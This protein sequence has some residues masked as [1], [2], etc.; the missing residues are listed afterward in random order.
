MIGTAS[1]SCGPQFGNTYGTGLGYNETGNTSL[2]VILSGAG[3]ITS[4]SVEIDGNGTAQNLSL[5]VDTTI[6]AGPTI[7]ATALNSSGI[8]I[9]SDGGNIV[10]STG[11]TTTGG[12]TGGPFPSANPQPGSQ[13]F[14]NIAG[15]AAETF[16]A[17]TVTINA[18]GNVTGGSGDGIQV[19]TI[20]GDVNIT[21]SGNGTS[22]IQ[23]TSPFTASAGIAVQTVGGNVTIIT[24]QG[25]SVDSVNGDGI[26]VASTSGNI[27][28][29]LLDGAINANT[30]GVG[31]AS[32]VS[33]PFTPL[34]SQPIILSPG[35]NLSTGGTIL[36][37]T[38]DN[39]N[40]KGPGDG[41]DTFTFGAGN[42]TVVVN[43]Q[44]NN[45]KGNGVLAE[46][47]GTGAVTVILGNVTTGCVQVDLP[48]P[49]YVVDTTGGP[50]RSASPPSSSMVRAT[51]QRRFYPP[52]PATS[53]S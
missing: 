22:Q 17:G 18:A 47:I 5:L 8:L 19:V 7:N 33:S 37:I 13:V 40:N 15:I 49:P 2:T 30:S 23:S 52:I 45:T 43:A 4:H 50:A 34:P 46:A 48:S 9:E 3:T 25:D 21:A 12:T 35:I 42:N 27:F 6:S 36:L 26:D 44:V 28:V 11:N 32:G 51:R 10:I 41:I 31:G 38:D 39:V 24:D 20:N 14:G 1:E 29:H 53:R 16:G